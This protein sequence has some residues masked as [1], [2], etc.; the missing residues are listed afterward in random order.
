MLDEPLA[1]IASETV[2]EEP[3][4]AIALEPETVAGETVAEGEALTLDSDGDLENSALDIEASDPE[5]GL[6]P[7]PE[8]G[9]EAELDW[10]PNDDNGPAPTLEVLFDGLDAL[11]DLPE[12]DRSGEVA[13]VESAFGDDGI[14]DR[15]SDAGAEPELDPEFADTLALESEA[16]ALEEPSPLAA[17]PVLVVDT[18]LGAEGS[19]GNGPDEST[20]A[21][22]TEDLGADTA[23][24]L[25]DELG[26]ESP[27][28]A[29]DAL[30]DVPGEAPEDA[31]EETLENDRV[32]PATLDAA[33]AEAALGLVSNDWALPVLDPPVLVPPATGWAEP[34][35]AI[36]APEDAPEDDLEF[37]EPP[38]VAPRPPEPVAPDRAELPLWF[39]GLDVG[40]TGL[41]A[42]LLERRGGQVYPIYWVDNAISGV[43]ADKFFR[44]PMLASVGLLDN[45]GETYQVQSVGS[46]A[47]TVSWSDTDSS[48]PETLLLKTLKPYLKLGIPLAAGE[49]TALEPQIQCSDRDRLPLKAFQDSLGDLLTTLTQGLTPDAAFTVGAVGLEADAIAAAFQQLQG[50][51]VSYPANWPDTYTFNLREAVLGSGLAPSPDQIYFVEDAIAAVLSGLPDPATPLP[52]GNGQ[53]MQQQTLYACPWT[54]GT[55]VI[56]AGATVTEVGLVNLPRSL[57]DL[58]YGD[59]TLHSMSYAGDAIDLDIVCHLLHPAEYRHSRS[60]E[61][62]DRNAAVG[63]WGWQ[64]AMPELEGAQWQ[65]LDLDGCDF[66]RPAEPDPAQRQRLYQRLDA[67][68]LGQTVLEAARHLKIILQHQPRF[69]LELADQHWVVR[70]KDLEDRIILP[71]IQ[72]INGHLNRLLSETGLTTQGI[73]QVICTGGSASLPKIAHWLRQKFPNA[74]IVQDTYHS[75]RPPSCSRVTY[76][77]VNLVRYP[78]VLDLTRHQY[79]DMFLLMELLRTL[80]EQP[81]PLSGI[82]HLLKERGLNVEACQAHLMALLEGRL[83]PSL[84]PNPQQAPVVLAASDD[85]VNLAATP[86][87]TRPGEVY[88]PNLEQGERLQA[89]MEQLLADKYQ[90]L[91]DPLLSQLTVLNV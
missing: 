1:E 11:L 81:M 56:S 2:L 89:Y 27:E 46:S 33:E 19:D 31:L 68:L 32:A 38:V 55:V 45:G 79:S 21:I 90:T 35:P 23:T 41:S 36:A 87:F 15:P 6:E 22:A 42:V 52:E 40:T 39:L 80:P 60:D 5:P 37:L 26:L 76:G 57:A 53:P 74:T 59:F 24:A 8:S 72:R 62:Y 65:D 50:V 12:D 73:N 29:I 14:F 7:G 77:L 16:L 34:E 78:Q 67:S 4:A 61:D 86:L 44:L 9:L 49:G 25:G 91:I 84:L 66:P 28:A 48:E 85:W 70:S 10:P 71:Y 30:E 64:A 75:D 69:E 17:D 58:T 88:V 47:L 13:L 20:L 18:D 51:V 3:L 63:G 43:T 82:L 83:P 54:G